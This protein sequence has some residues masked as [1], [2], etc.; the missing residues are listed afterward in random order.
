M[1]ALPLTQAKLQK[2]CSIDFGTVVESLK[3]MFKERERIRAAFAQ[4]SN[5]QLQPDLLAKTWE[6]T[7]QSQ[8]KVLMTDRILLSASRNATV[9]L[10]KSI[11]NCDNK[12][13]SLPQIF[14]TEFT[15]QPF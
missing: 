13:S 10:C 7:F 5:T 1:A 6:A 11:A 12:I 8:A 2:E 9:D 3:S 15:E 4:S 14:L